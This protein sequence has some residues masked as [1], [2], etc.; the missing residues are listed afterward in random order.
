[1]IDEFHFNGIKAEDLL[2]VAIR[3]SMCE[4]V[5]I[6]LK[7]YYHRCPECQEYVVERGEQKRYY[8]QME[9]EYYDYDDPGPDGY[10]L[11]VDWYK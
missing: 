5:F 10:D 8:E 11:N 6:P 1:M 3:C 7:P 4:E 9:M 2:Q